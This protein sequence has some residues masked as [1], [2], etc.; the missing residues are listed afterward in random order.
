MNPENHVM[1][2]EIPGTAEDERLAVYLETGHGAGSSLSLCQQSW[3]E[4]IGWF[5]QSRV[6]ID[7]AQLPLLR[8]ALGAKAALP[9]KPQRLAEP[10]TAHRL[11]VVG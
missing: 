4:G 2:A 7:P 8:Q 5:T 6:E 11:R 10:K 9:S 3:A 1:L